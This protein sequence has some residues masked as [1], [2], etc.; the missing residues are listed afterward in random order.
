M[1]VGQHV[2][3]QTHL[4]FMYHFLVL[5]Y[6]TDIVAY[7][8]LLRKPEGKTP[9]GTPRHSWEDNIKMDL[10]EIGWRV[11]TSFIWLKI[12]ISDRL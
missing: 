7:R 2:A 4:F 3:L 8:I 9:L 12:R 1:K 6:A 5:L 11:S 10:K